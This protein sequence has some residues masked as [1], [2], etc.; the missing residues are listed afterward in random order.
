M[1]TLKRSLLQNDGYTLLSIL[2]IITLISMIGLLALN[3]T[4][5][6]MRFVSINETNIKSNADAQMAIEDA[7]AQIESEIEKLNSEIERGNTSISSILNRFRNTMDHLTSLA[8]SP[9]TI[10]RT[11][12]ENG[13]DGLY[14]ERL[15]IRAP[16]GESDKSLKK[17]III[18]SEGV[19][20]VFEYSVVSEGNIRFNGASYIEGDVLIKG[21]L[22]TG[23]KGKYISGNSE[24]FVDT[25]YPAINGNLSVGGRYFYTNVFED[26]YWETFWGIPI[27]YVCET[28]Y[29]PATISL[30]RI[31]DYFSVSPDIRTK[32]AD[33]QPINVLKLINDKNGDLHNR[34][35]NDKGDYPGRWGFLAPSLYQNDVSFNN[36]QI[37]S[38]K[39]LT[40]HGNVMVRGNLNIE[41]GGELIVNGSIKVAGKA[42][43]NGKLVLT[44]SHDYIYIAGDTDTN[45][46]SLQGQMYVNGSL[47]VNNNL[48]TN[49]TIYVKE[50]ATIQELT[51]SEGTL[52]ILANG[53]IHISNNNQYS[54]VPK[55]MNAFFYSN[56]DMEIYGVGSNIKI[57]GGIYG[58]Q[59]TLNAVKGRTEN[60][61][62]ADS[63]KV[64]SLYF[65]TNQDQIEPTNSR[66]S[67]IYNR[68][69]IL[70]PPTGIP[71]VSKLKL[72][73]IDLRYEE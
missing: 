2:L 60:R 53:N 57:I 6:S 25:S 15:I 46:F 63:T 50:N 26:C 42:N 59:I 51:N 9:F 70:N 35:K 40:V 28:K 5:T 41:A 49:G 12:L 37:P 11:T 19:N 61:L 43:F 31:K 47:T 4:V 13:N 10:S 23:N 44:T 67:I 34:N 29:L 24:V 1:V 68:D 62:F 64:G 69:I 32:T 21:D 54:E 66:L 38:G 8:G 18:S 56:A 3:A 45:N 7:M 17:T 72:Q 20:E 55:K 14:R 33:V 48:N 52:V 71:K 22:E 65:Q 27:R 73:E 16:I 36:L 58:R 39:K 30:A